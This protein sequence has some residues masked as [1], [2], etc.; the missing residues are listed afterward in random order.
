MS[1]DNLFKIGDIVTFKTHPLLYDIYIKGDGKLVP[2]F[3]IVSEI[4]F[5]DKKKL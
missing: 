4:C 1:L 3:M 5:E 2:P